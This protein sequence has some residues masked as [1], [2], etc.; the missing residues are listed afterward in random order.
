MEASGR[1]EVI[2]K[3][4]GNWKIE[5]LEEGKQTATITVGSVSKEVNYTVEG[6]IAG[7]FAAGGSL[8]YVGAGLVI[9]ISLAV[10]AIGFRFL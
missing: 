9:L 1:G 3:G 2:N 6:N 4:Q 7:L 8:Y 10:V 5:T